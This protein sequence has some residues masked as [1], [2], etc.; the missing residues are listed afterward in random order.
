MNIYDLP[1]GKIKDE[2]VSILAVGRDLRLER[3]VSMGQAS[4]WYDQMED[5]Y[6]ILVQGEA[7]LVFAEGPAVNLCAGDTLLIPAHQ[8]HRVSAT[9]V[10]PPCIWLCVFYQG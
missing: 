9:S 7:T 2:L 4:D 10:E 6:V 5:E 1:Q 8:K 3:I